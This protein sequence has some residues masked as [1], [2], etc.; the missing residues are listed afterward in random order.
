MVSISVK[1]AILASLTLGLAS[2][3]FSAYAMPQGAHDAQNIDKIA[4]AAKV[5]DVEG[6]G[7]A[8]IKW[9][10]FSVDAGETVN[11]KGMSKMLNYVD[12]KNPSKISGAINAKGVD[13]YVINPSGVLFNDSSKVNVA[14]LFV[15]SRAMTDAALNKFAKDGVN[16]LGTPVTAADI[17]RGGRK[18]EE[19]LGA[20]DIADGDIAL[21]GKVTADTMTIEGNVV[22]LKNTQDY[23]DRDGNLL[24][25]DA[26]KLVSDNPIEVGYEVEDNTVD[27]FT[28]ESL[29]GLN[30][31]SGNIQ[32]DSEN[33]YLK[34]LYNGDEKGKFSGS[35][36]GYETEKLNRSSGIIQNGRLIDSAEDFSKIEDANGNIVNGEY[37]LN[38]DIDFNGQT[39]DPL[40]NGYD[41]AKKGIENEIFILNGLNHSIKNLKTGDYGLFYNL[42]QPAIVKN[43][44]FENVSGPNVLSTYFNAAEAKNLNFLSGSIS[45]AP[46]AGYIEIFFTRAQQ[47]KY[48]WS[49]RSFPFTYLKNIENHIDINGN[50]SA[51]GIYANAYNPN[52]LM[53]N[54]VNYGNI[55]TTQGSYIGGIGGC[56]P[57]P[58]GRFVNYNL[59]NFGDITASGTYIGGLFGWAEPSVYNQKA[60]D[61]HILELYNVLNTGK[62]IANGTYVG[63]LI[64][65]TN[66]AESFSFELHD[67]FNLGSVNAKT[68]G[69]YAG[70][71]I[72]CSE[73][74][75]NMKDVFNA[76]DVKSSSREVIP[77]VGGLIGFLN[78]SCHGENHFSSFEN[79]YNLGSVKETTGDSYIGGFIGYADEKSLSFKNSY[80]LG[81]VFSEGG[82]Y[83]GGIVGY[84]SIGDAS[85]ENVYNRGR[86]LTKRPLFN[87]YG[88]EGGIFGAP[89]IKDLSYQNVK[90]RGD[91]EKEGYGDRFFPISGL[92]KATFSP[93]IGTSPRAGKQE[94]NFNYEEYNDSK[95][96]LPASEIHVSDI[97]NKFDE[98]KWSIREGDDQPSLNFVNNL[99]TN[100]GEVVASLADV[101][102]ANNNMKTPDTHSIPVTENPIPSQS[103]NLDLLI[104]QGAH[105]TRNIEKIESSDGRM[106]VSGHDNAIIK[107]KDFSVGKD[108]SVLFRGMDN[109]LNIVDQKNPSKI[110][111]KI[112]ANGV[113]L[114]ILNPSGVLFGDSSIVNAGSLAISSRSMS[115]DILDKFTKDGVSPLDTPVASADIGKGGRKSDEILGSYDIADG[116]IAVLGKIKASSLLVEGN[117]VQLK[118]TKDY[119]DADGNV[120][121]GN[122]VTLVSD[123]PVEVGYEVRNND[124]DPFTNESLTKLQDKSQKNMSNKY[125]KALYN[126]DASN[127]DSA[128]YLGYVVKQTNGTKGKIQDARLVSSVD[129]FSMLEDSDGKI[130]NG[131]YM[132]QNDID[133]ENKGLSSLWK[134]AAFSSVDDD[135]FILNGLN[136]QMENLDMGGESMFKNILYPSVIKNLRFS[137]RKYVLGS[138]NPDM[139][140]AESF[141]GKTA[142]NISFVSGTVERYPFAESIK[143]SEDEI[144]HISNV[145][146]GMTIN[147][148]ETNKSGNFGGIFGSSSGLMDFHNVVNYG[149]F[150]GNQSAEYIGGIGGSVQ[151]PSN[152]FYNLA[153][154]GNLGTGYRQGGKGFGGLFGYLEGTD[155]NTQLKFQNTF[156]AGNVIGHDDYAGGFF[157]FVKL[158]GNGSRIDTENSFNVGEIASRGTYAGGFAGTVE[159]GNAGFKNFY[160]NGNV[161]LVT[162]K[163]K[164]QTYGGGFIGK[165]ESLD[166][167]GKI[168]I[169]K[170]YHV[171][172]VENTFGTASLGGIFGSIENVRN[173][174]MKDAYTVGTVEGT[175]SSSLGGIIGNAGAAEIS[176]DNVLKTGK[177]I[178]KDKSAD[179]T[180]T[181]HVFGVTTATVV[182]SQGLKWDAGYVVDDPHDFVPT[183]S[184]IGNDESTR[185]GV[186]GI[187]LSDVYDTFDISKNGK[188]QST[189]WRIYEG[190]GHPLLNFAMRPA[191]VVGTTILRANGTV[192]TVSLPS[193]IKLTSDEKDRNLYVDSMHIYGN[194]L[195]G[196]T[197]DIYSQEMWSDQFGYNFRFIA[198]YGND[199]NTAYLVIY[200]LPKEKFASSLGYS[201]NRGRYTGILKEKHELLPQKTEAVTQNVDVEEREDNLVPSR[202]G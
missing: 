10:D 174:S 35:A 52:L 98:G 115:E 148:F 92:Y 110:Y 146:N 132:L 156:N 29:Q 180:K 117:Q 101:V 139:L 134:T 49:E 136:H 114:F 13:L 194:N 186:G 178:N 162:P 39:P 8:V 73:A 26:V 158:K 18:S 195:R 177:V 55:R 109:L 99:V 108:A 122:K 149:D 131:A 113:N 142:K 59:A 44:K 9:K 50:D 6:H 23:T 144:V 201:M 152:S 25:G 38:R 168:S 77:Y 176:F 90:W 47:A 22:Q 28:G 64:G 60:G 71:L 93:V 16:P 84:V 129:D 191:D 188:N 128:S 116:D 159:A 167:H 30:S 96:A 5:M 62:I 95:Q 183:A 83:A 161:T 51:G 173:I 140:F 45:K 3:P 79:I 164:A 120:L 17:G 138:E 24:K 20:Y 172:N 11:F 74:S 41:Y 57:A 157:G 189:I 185:V 58:Q 163:S 135:T 111:G 89:Y 175:G 199:I 86:V 70:G 102:S 78:G 192:Q 187:R 65:K 145:E 155:N 127:T 19:I 66:G 151:T 31:V 75:T 33:K 119:T 1:R 103:N 202:N 153:N 182:R 137:T 107:W 150:N 72:G 170:A 100:K 125:L 15:S 193:I 200:D 121:S 63:G 69:R 112:D 88:M 37:L 34:A 196:K 36:L 118:N 147:S 14:N 105:D 123:T 4:Q 154:F 97:Y 197:P 61:S 184:G 94:T 7:N 2:F 124:E 143:S 54:I 53:N 179:T 85:L 42:M 21:L 56:I 68:F 82:S 141:S 48:P 76:A 87:Y 40:W 133:F 43:L 165:F 166:S 126:G 104:P 27:P 46:L 198:P 169:E 67:S 80:M 32:K 171:G 12:Q 190:H 81:D 106:S 91:Y 130:I 160:S 181:N